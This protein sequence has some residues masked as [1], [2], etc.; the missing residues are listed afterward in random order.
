[1]YEVEAKVNEMISHKEKLSLSRAR[2][3]LEMMRKYLGVE[4]H[5]E[6]KKIVHFHNLIS[7]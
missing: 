1:M 6:K 2:S 4:F 3:E 7:S 5:E